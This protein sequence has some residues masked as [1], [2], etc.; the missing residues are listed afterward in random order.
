MK[1]HHLNGLRA[2]E[3]S[4]RHLSFS[5]AAKELNVTPAAI[6]QQVKLL[7]EWLGISL[8]ERRTSG[9]SRLVLTKEALLG[10]PEITRGFEHLSQ[11]LDLL[12]PTE[13]SPILTVAVSPAFA[14][15]WLLMRIDDFQISYPEWDLRLDTNIRTVDYLTES[16]DVGIRYGK[17]QWEGLEASLLMTESVFPVCSPELLNKGIESI[18]SLAQFPLLHDISLPK[19]SGFPSWKAWFEQNDIFDVNTE[20]GLK[21]NNSASVIQ[22]AING[23]GIALGRSV[24]VKDDLDCGRLVQLFPD[25]ESTTELAYYVVWKQKGI[26]S[27]KIS[28]FKEWLHQQVE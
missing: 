17:G 5:L 15:K 16:I 3:A 26:V 13:N 1:L 18:E 12:K 19:E 27:D 10:L 21:I 24:L 28:V 9:A 23:Q 14:A 4:A 6:G 25:L 11:G 20:K 8:F 7:E 22:A 2:F